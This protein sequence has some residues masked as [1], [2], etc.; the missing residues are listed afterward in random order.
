MSTQSQ[1]TPGAEPFILLELAGAT[2]AVRSRD[3]QQ[4]EMPGQVT[5]VPNAPSFVQGVVSVRGE[6]IPVVNLRARFGF[7]S[8]AQTARTRLVV[9][10]VGKR[11]VGLLV[12]SAREFASIDPTSIQPPP[13]SIA[14]TSGRYLEGIAQQ[15]ERIVLVLDVNEL[16]D[17]HAF[18]K[19][20]PLTGEGK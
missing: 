13:A 12:D 15:G 9:V 4:L 5:T 3:I 20:S 16:L 1:V 14:G 10:R 17:P 7:P 6:V 11:V 8:V 2:Y 18:E 19:E